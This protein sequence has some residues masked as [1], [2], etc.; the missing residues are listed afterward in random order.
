MD[1]ILVT[2]L[3]G[4]LALL[5]ATVGQAGGTAYI[6]AMAL[7]GFP[8]DVMRSTSLLLNVIAAGYATWRLNRAG[9]IDWR[10]LRPITAASLPMAFVGGLLVLQPQSFRI[11]VGVVLIVAAALTVRRT[12]RSLPWAHPLPIPLAAAIG[13]GVGLA[14]GLTGVGGGVF[15][16]PLLLIGGWATPKQTAGVSAPFILANSAIA[17]LATRLAG[18]TV[19]DGILIFAAGSL[20]GAVLGTA[21]G[22]RWVSPRM[23]RIILAAILLASG[24]RMLML[25]A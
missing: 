23:I 14:S 8:H 10:P 17:F 6:A 13:A 16:A 18:Q 15:L 11:V 9:A 1:L 7:F 4:L 25:A 19:A 24:L 21:I 12:N 3:M 22:L 5:Y 20:A 2:A